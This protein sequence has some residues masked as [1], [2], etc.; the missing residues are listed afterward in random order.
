MDEYLTQILFVLLSGAGVAIWYLL[1]RYNE[2]KPLLENLDVAQRT[3]DLKKTLEEHNYTLDD[4]KIFQSNLTGS[5]EIAKK[6]S[7]S[8]AKEAE[9]ISDMLMSN[10]VTQLEMN[11][12]AHRAYQITSINLEQVIGEIQ[13]HLTTE[14]SEY[15][16]EA[17]NLWRKYHEANALFA[18]SR[19][20]GGS[21]RP[22]IYLSSLQSTAISRLVELETKLNYMKS[23]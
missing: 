9:K 1:T 15:F 18:A 22:L 10:A 14:E 4:L 21:I 8:F 3:A 2:K 23:M 19:Y 17:Q 16:T 11:E 6:L 13:K 20:E 5:S 7:T 12:A